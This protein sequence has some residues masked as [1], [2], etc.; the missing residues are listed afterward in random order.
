VRP[1][2]G[3]DGFI[4]SAH[5][6]QGLALVW[7]PADAA[8]LSL[9]SRPLADGSQA[10]EVELANVRVPAQNLLAEGPAAV[11]ALTRG[12]DE[13]LVLTSAELLALVRSML[14]MTL[15]YLRS[16]VQFGKPIGSF[17]A[18]QHR[19][20]DLLIQQE[21][22]ASVL[23]QA[24]ALLDDPKTSATARSA[25]A[26]RVKARASDAGLQVAREAVQLH[27]AIGVTDEY[28]LGLYLQRALVLSAWLGNGTQQRRR[29]A[30]LTRNLTE[31]EHA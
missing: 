23:A 30:A 28:D 2:A 19:A 29:Y 5:G 11:A 4:V 27:G 13:T 3:A 10:A 26:S 17:Q 20:A 6:A 22:T 15:E 9:H 21:L 7:V 8:G 1:G 31:Q 16:R 18:L 25:M 24:L 14:A 12:Y